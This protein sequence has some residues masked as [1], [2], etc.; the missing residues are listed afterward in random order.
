MAISKAM[1]HAILERDGHTCQYCGATAPDVKLQIDHVVPK[2]LGGKD[3]PDNL[4]AACEACNSGK[5][6]SATKT[7]VDNSALRERLAELKERRELL[8]A[9]SSEQIIISQEKSETLTRIGARVMDALQAQP[10]HHPY[11]IID[12]EPVRIEIQSFRSA[13]VLHDESEIMQAI[14]ITVDRLKSFG[15]T[16]LVKYS[17]GVLRSMRKERAGGD[18]K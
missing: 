11:A 12:V 1:R 9:I 17:L 3:D 6:A 8:Q 16:A 15:L 7:R 18:G 14:D 13:M 2:T 10:D 5:G 4:I